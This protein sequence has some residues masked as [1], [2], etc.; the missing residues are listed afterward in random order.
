M[1]AMFGHMEADEAN[2]F[3]ASI[4]PDVMKSLVRSG[5]GTGLRDHPFNSIRGG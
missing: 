4:A 2:K 5:C 1:N 3:I